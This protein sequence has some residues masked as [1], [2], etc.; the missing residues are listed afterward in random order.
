MVERM[1]PYRF[2]PYRFAPEE[3][4]LLMSI[5]HVGTAIPAA[6]EARMTERALMR[7]DTDWHLDRLYDFASELGI[8]TL[9][10][11]WSRYVVDLNRPPDDA[12]LYPGRPSTGLLPQQDFAGNPLY[13]PGAEP[14]DEE[15]ENRLRTCWL[16]YHQRLERELASIRRRHGIA[17]LFDCHSI[18]SE[19]PRLFEG[20]L[21][22]FNLGT[23]HGGAC[24]PGLRLRLAEALGNYG[25]E[26]LVVDGRFTGGF[27]TRQYGD[28]DNRIH[29]F[30]LELSMATYC[31]ELPPWNYAPDKAAEV[32]PAL[33]AMLEAA[34]TWAREHSQ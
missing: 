29:S 9:Q 14:D 30:Q 18:L 21:P 10:A 11:V 23:A 31:G 17:I 25:E 8:P 22:D 28:P 16:P 3:A 13:H 1:N 32:R 20:K 5:P 27:I 15:R 33:R 7:P 2:T 12:P 4:P 6:V 24:H 26:R 34:L 19:V